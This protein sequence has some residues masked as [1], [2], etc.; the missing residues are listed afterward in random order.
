MESPV[1]TLPALFKQLGLPDDAISIDQFI[2]SHSPLKPDLHLSDATVDLIGDA[3]AEEVLH[4]VGRGRLDH[5]AAGRREDE[6]VDAVGQHVRG[7]ADQG[8]GA[9]VWSPLGWGRLTGKLR[10]GQPLPA[11][12]RLHD[13]ADMGPTLMI[14]AIGQHGRVDKQVIDKPEGVAE[15]PTPASPQIHKRNRSSDDPDPRFQGQS[16]SWLQ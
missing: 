2:A 16:R 11:T 3:G 8:V 1:H 12:S 4:R 7:F 13:T 5:V 14:L 9:V 10:R 6:Q 15:H